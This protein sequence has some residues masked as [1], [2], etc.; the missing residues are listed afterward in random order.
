MTKHAAQ[1]W[2][3]A[4]RLTNLPAAGRYGLSAFVTC[5]QA[6]SYHLL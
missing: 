6:G 1:Q 5:R 3:A 4:I 2:L